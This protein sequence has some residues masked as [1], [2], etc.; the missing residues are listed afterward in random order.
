M[1]RLPDDCIYIRQINTEQ[2][3]PA[4]LALLALGW[5]TLLRKRRR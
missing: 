1:R 5:L 3:A 2:P 4:T